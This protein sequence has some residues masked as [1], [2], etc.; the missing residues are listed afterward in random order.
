[1]YGLYEAVSTH[2]TGGV[3]NVVS[4]VILEHVNEPP[5]A[6]G[7]VHRCSAVPALGN[8]P[9][10]DRVERTEVR[11]PRPYLVLGGSPE[12]H[13]TSGVCAEHGDPV[14]FVTHLDDGRLDGVQP[15]PVDVLEVDGEHLATG[16]ERGV[17]PRLAVR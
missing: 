8:Q 12:V 2:R 1:V 4:K 5:V 3:A 14:R 9:E 7:H 11:V 15:A 16:H 10:A 6:G 17:Q 13:A